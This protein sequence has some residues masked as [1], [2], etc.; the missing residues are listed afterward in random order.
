MGVIMKE[1]SEN[2]LYQKAIS[3]D[4]KIIYIYILNN[5][6]LVYKINQTY[7]QVKPTFIKKSCTAS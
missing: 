2:E 6:K 3:K 4:Y 7:K 1:L 5:I